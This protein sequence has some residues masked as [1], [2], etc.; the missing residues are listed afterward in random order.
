MQIFR[1]VLLAM[2]LIL[3]ATGALAGG[4]PA[5]GPEQAA[6]LQAGFDRLLATYV[7]DGLVDY[8]AWSANP[9]DTTALGHYVDGLAALEPGAWPPHDALAYWINLYNAV[10][11]RLVLDNYPLDS[12]KDVGGFLKKSPWDRELVTV[13]GRPLTLNNI[14]NDIIR[15]GFADPRVHFA[16]NCASIGCPPLGREAYSAERIDAQLDAACRRALDRDQWV[17]VRGKDLELTKIFDW[18]REDFTKGG[19]TVLDFIRRYRTGPLPEGEPKI[20]FAPYDWSLN[21]TP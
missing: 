17:K 10:T 13:G 18:Y 15:P 4:S 14:E 8:A 16:L 21:R 5:T 12:I 3:P 11:L 20:S 6:L 2:V 7:R 9:A 1:K 19:G